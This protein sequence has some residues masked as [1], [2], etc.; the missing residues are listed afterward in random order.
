MESDLFEWISNRPTN[1]HI[2][3]A[4]LESLAH[5]AGSAKAAFGLEALCTRLGRSDEAYQYAN[6][7][8]RLWAKA[9]ATDLENLRNDMTR[10]AAH[11][12]IPATSAAA[13]R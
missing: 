6:L 10:R 11:V 7:G 12:P 2:N 13:G 9:N 4:F 8:R 1:L 5:D 3:E